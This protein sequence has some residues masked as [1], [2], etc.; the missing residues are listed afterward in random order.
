MVRTLTMVTMAMLA[1]RAFAVETAEPAEKPE[2]PETELGKLAASLKPGEM[3]ELKTKGYTRDVLQ[4]WYEWDHDEKG[5]R[6]YGSGRMYN[7]AM[8][9]SHDAKWDPKTRQVLFIGIGHY[10]AL[11]FLSYSADSNAWTLMPVPTWCDPRRIECQV[12][13]VLPENRL[14]LSAGRAQGMWADAELDL[15]RDGK[16]VGLARVQELNEKD[17]IALLLLPVGEIQV[18]DIARNPAAPAT[19]KN[20]KGTGRIWPRGHIYDRLAISP[21]HRKFAINWHGLYLYDIDRREWTRSRVAAAG[22]KDALQVAEYFPEMKT[23]IYTTKWGK[24]L[25]AWNVEKKTD[26]SLGSYPLG[27]HGVMEY[28]PVHKV[29]VFGL[30]DGN[31]NLCRMDAQGKVKKLK[32]AP[33]AVSCREI[34]KLLC[35]PVSGEFLA[36]ENL[37][38]KKNQ[39]DNRRVYAFH[40]MRDEWKEIS[41]LRFPSGLGVAVDTYGVL[42]FCTG[43]QV[44]VYK[45]KPVF[46]EANADGVAASDV[47]DGTVKE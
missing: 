30:G 11:K 6:I 16:V 17:S 39:K 19:S 23:F 25:R 12:V 20:P 35:D 31:L 47:T 8:S 38:L 28:N 18:G 36:Q 15:L 9:W 40:P 7:V 34:S 14:K 4:S 33:I 41:G 43:G 29:L 37:R 10:T 21:E 22:G 2:A 45:H 26:R 42:M 46:T 13:E 44:F 27:M 3:K 32:P 1:A 5:T 24:D